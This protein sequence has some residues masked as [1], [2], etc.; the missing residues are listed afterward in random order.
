MLQLKACPKC[1]TGD[2]VL[3]KDVYG[4]FRQCIQCSFIEDLPTDAAVSMIMV[5]RKKAIAAVA[6]P[7]EGP[8]AA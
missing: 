7:I 3:E 2:M 4:W 5:L 8:R 6:V 1:K